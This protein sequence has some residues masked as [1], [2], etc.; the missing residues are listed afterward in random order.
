ME[1]QSFG[2][3]N[4]K[5]KTGTECIFLTGQQIFGVSVVVVTGKW[6]QEEGESGSD[7][8]SLGMVWG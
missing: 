8:L 2:Y 1:F 4:R 6:D 5:V 3:Y 7:E